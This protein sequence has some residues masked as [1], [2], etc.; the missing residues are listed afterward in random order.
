[1]SIVK[2]VYVAVAGFVSL[3]GICGL[4][5]V[6]SI[7]CDLFS[8]AT[9]HVF[10]FYG[11]AARLYSFQTRSLSALWRLFRGKKWNQ[12]KCRVDS[13]SYEYDRLFIGGISFT[14][15]VFLLPT[16]LLYYCVFLLLRLASM[17]FLLLM[18]LLIAKLSVAPA[19]ALLL[20]CL[21]S[22]Q[23]VSGLYFLSRP[24]L[25][26]IM[27]PA[28]LS[29]GQ[30]F[31]TNP[32]HLRNPLVLSRQQLEVGRILGRIVWGELVSLT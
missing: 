26:A 1:M 14:I 20:S 24:G 27:R 18:R 23:L 21:S 10:C 16:V 8:L 7:I 17:L 2:P 13:Y 5:C 4:T 19:Y 32:G 9:I 31:H 11:Y 15:V 28:F 22:R 3:L 30:L 12:L 25:P 29:C 6:L